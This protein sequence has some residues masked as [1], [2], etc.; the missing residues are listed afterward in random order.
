[1]QV[2]PNPFSDVAT[3]AFNLPEAGEVQLLVSDVTG[4][5]VMSRHTNFAAGHQQWRIL[6]RELPGPGVYYCRLVSATQ[7][8]PAAVGL[9]FG[10]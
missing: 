7:A 9:I 2:F 4:V 3:L 6:G 1:M 8:L 10:Q 5:P